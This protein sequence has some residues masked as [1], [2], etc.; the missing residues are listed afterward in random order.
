[1]DKHLTKVNLE[2][3]IRSLS[4]IISGEKV[5][6][7]GLCSA[8]NLQPIY[9]EFGNI[10]EGWE[11][12]SGDAHYPVPATDGGKAK[13]LFFATYSTDMYDTNTKYGALRMDLAKYLLTLLTGYLKTLN[14]KKP[15]TH[16][17]W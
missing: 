7:R 5:T 14:G 8:C 15:R 6:I 1:M 2:D 13:D 17:Q 9:K 10:F 3:S 11:H 12:Y 4:D 16:E